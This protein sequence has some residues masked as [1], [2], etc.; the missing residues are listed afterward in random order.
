MDALDRRKLV[1]INAAV[2]AQPI[3]SLL[4]D[5]EINA[6]QNGI[7]EYHNLVAAVLEAIRVFGAS[8]INSVSVIWLHGERTGN[9]LS[10]SN[11][12]NAAIF[13]RFQEYFSD[14]VYLREQLLVD[15]GIPKLWF[16]INR[17]GV[18]ET[19]FSQRF[20]SILNDLGY[21]QIELA[22]VNDLFLPLSILPRTFSKTQGTLGDDALHYSSIGYNNLGA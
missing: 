7:N 9:E 12:D 10:Q 6:T 20:A 15:L 16:F 18:V 19:P 13:E 3:R 22:R 11:S 21:W 1:L 5:G 4:P 2:G 17:V 8:N 14:L